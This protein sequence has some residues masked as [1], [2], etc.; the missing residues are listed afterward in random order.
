MK[1]LML[2]TAALALLFAGFVFA[3]EAELKPQTT[4]PV[5]G[6]KI[7]TNSYTDYQGQRIYHCCDACKTT[8]L[9]DP[10]KYFKKIAED[11]VILENIQ[12]TCPVMG[13]KIDKDVYT[14]YNG[15]RV[16]FCC[17]S[18]KKKFAKEPEK[19]LNKLPGK[20]LNKDEESMEMKGHKHKEHKQQ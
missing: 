16:Y 10:E 19:Y 12:K 1:S 15:R 5:M 3:D 8:F 6:G 13:G 7:D 14:D 18:C 9:K 20:N 4:C 17:A 11:S 2:L